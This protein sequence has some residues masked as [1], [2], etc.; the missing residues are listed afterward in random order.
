M[1]D[2]VDRET[3]LAAALAG[4]RRAAFGWAAAVALVIFSG[5]LLGLTWAQFAGGL[6]ELA[7]IFGFFFPPSPGGFLDEIMWGL[8]ETVAI[9]FLGTLLAAIA[10][11]PLG[12]LGAKNVVANFLFHSS[13]RRFFDGVRAID[14]LIWAL[15]FVGIVGLGPQAGVLAIAFSDTGTLA[16]LF[17]EA[18]EN[19]ERDQVEG[20]TASGASKSQTIR[21]AMLPQVVPIMLSHTLYFFESNVRSAAI[22]G[23][24]G[25]GGIGRILSE[26]VRGGYWEEVAFI[27]IV[28]LITVALIDTLSKEV[29]MRIISR[30]T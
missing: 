6:G 2:A 14:A 20:V 28:I 16:K 9:A 12:L 4:Q 18:T 19:V 24:V 15:I 26:R 8:V 11:L 25:A 29:R 7:R 30:G 21:F 13:L 23:I 27:T 5:W 22:L 10:S 17:A 1:R 3:I